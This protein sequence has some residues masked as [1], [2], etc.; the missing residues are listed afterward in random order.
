MPVFKS[1]NNISHSYGGLKNVINYITSGEKERIY[2]VEGIGLSDNKDMAYKEMLINK[3]GF[4]KEDGRQY[5]QFIL[6]FGIGID[7]ET[8]YQIGVKFAEENLLKRGYKSI[9]AVH[10]DKDHKHVHIITDSVNYV[11]G[12]KFHE[13]ER[14]ALEKEKNRYKNYNKDVNTSEVILEDLIESLDEISLEYGILPLKKEKS[15]SKNITD[16]EKYKTLEKEDSFR[17]KIASIY[18]KIAIMP[19]TNK[20]NIFERL[21]KEGVYIAQRNDGKKNFDIEKKTLTLAIKYVKNGKELEG[22][23]RLKLLEKEESYRFNVTENVFAFDYV[24]NREVELAKNNI[25]N[26]EKE[27]NYNITLDEIKKEIEKDI[28][29]TEKEWRDELIKLLEK[30]HNR[31][32][33]TLEQIQEVFKP[34]ENKENKYIIDYTIKALKEDLLEDDGTV[35]LNDIGSALRTV[36]PL[37]KIKENKMEIIDESDYTFEYN[38]NEEKKWSYKD[39]ISISS[40]NK[41]EEKEKE[42]EKEYIREYKATPNPNKDTD[43]EIE[44]KKPQ[45]KVVVQEV[46][47]IKKKKTF[48]ELKEDI[49]KFIESKGD[50][51]LLDAVNLLEDYKTI[52][53]KEIID[54]IIKVLPSV[55]E[56]I[57]GYKTVVAEDFRQNLEN[58]LINEFKEE[59]EN[60]VNKEKKFEYEY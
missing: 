26:K 55:S 46:Q 58:K 16:K 2:K 35:I 11:T 37:I 28:P 5:K 6:S 14:K 23:C 18:E 42:F 1:V 30:E 17:N 4:G 54:Y 29:K 10:D 40:I 44:E 48:K 53:N 47:E 15:K 50:L 60:K 57:D 12:M 13:I 56:N 33:L 32:R 21:E 9:L 3:K 38:H 31:K 59:K 19:S 45:E 25:E 7:A 24:F 52:E 36:L 34:V 39:F 43:E 22:K 20:S 41:K 8:V 51:I 49:Y 27:Y